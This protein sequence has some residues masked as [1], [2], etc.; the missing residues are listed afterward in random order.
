MAPLGRTILL[1][2]VL[3][4]LSG[5]AAAATHLLVLVVLTELG[6]A[7]STL[8]S[9]VGFICALPVNYSLQ[10]RFVFNKSRQHTV[11]FMRYLAVTL[12]TLGLNTCLFWLLTTGL[13]IFYVASRSSR[14]GSSYP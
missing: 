8:A 5:S 14:S 2:F 3:Y 11:F 4:G 10:H 7:P 12:L 9:A 13:G 1:Q 6:G